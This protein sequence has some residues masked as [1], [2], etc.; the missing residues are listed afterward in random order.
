M[1]DVRCGGAAVGEEEVD[2]L[3]RGRDCHHLLCGALGLRPRAGGG[4]GD[5]QVGHHEQL[6][7]QVGHH[8][9]TMA[10]WLGRK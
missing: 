9:W 4:R 8:T 1:Q 6:D 2:P 5:E 7:E 10:G 3:L